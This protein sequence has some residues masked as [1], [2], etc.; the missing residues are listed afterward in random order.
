M[1][2]LLLRFMRNSSFIC[3]FVLA[4]QQLLIMGGIGSGG[5]RDG[6]GR[7]PIDGVPRAK[8]SFSVPQY[9]IDQVRELAERQKISTSQLVTELLEK[10]LR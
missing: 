10:A 7:K 4:K 1:L 9:L 2:L 3:N 5:A 6:A 8:V